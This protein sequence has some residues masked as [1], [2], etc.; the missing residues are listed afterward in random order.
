MDQPRAAKTGVGVLFA[1][2]GGKKFFQPVDVVIAIGDVGV[3]QQVAKQ[4]NCGLDSVNHELIERAPQTHHA[5]HP[6]PAVHDQLADQ[7]VV[8]GRDL[9]ALIDT[10]IDADAET[11]GVW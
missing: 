6:G 3:G 9:V 1:G 10:G 2:F 11:P 4:W 8:I 7:A 5:L